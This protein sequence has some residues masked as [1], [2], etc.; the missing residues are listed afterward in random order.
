MQKTVQ[1]YKDVHNICKKMLIARKLNLE[2]K[3]LIILM[4]EKSVGKNERNLKTL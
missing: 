3:K 2:K 4:S 1:L